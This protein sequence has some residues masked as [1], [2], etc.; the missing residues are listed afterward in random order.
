M[1][2]ERLARLREPGGRVEYSRAGRTCRPARN[3]HSLRS[4]RGRRSRVLRPANRAPREPVG[5]AA[6][7]WPHCRSLPHAPEN[8]KRPPTINGRGP[9][10]RGGL[11]GWPRI[12]LMVLPWELRCFAEPVIPTNRL[13]HTISATLA[14]GGAGHP[15]PR[16]SHT[17]F[18]CAVR[19][20]HRAG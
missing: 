18:L 4:G 9:S 7:L 2:G 6:L 1:F 12:H 5:M 15:Y 17:G 10:V 16:R 3:S 11:A 13:A 8:A 20:V 19:A 14:I